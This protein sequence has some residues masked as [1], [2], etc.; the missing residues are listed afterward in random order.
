MFLQWTEI[1]LRAV[2][3]SFLIDEAKSRG[4]SEISLDSTEMGRALYKSLGFDENK[5]AMNII[6]N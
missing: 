4:V 5:E 2:L 3:Q 1:K 6:L